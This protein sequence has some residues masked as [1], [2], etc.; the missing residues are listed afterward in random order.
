MNDIPDQ[1]DDSASQPK[2]GSDSSE[3]W[4]W[5]GLVIKPLAFLICG[6]LL[7]AGLGVMQK[8][9]FLSSGGGHGL[10]HAGAANSAAEYICPMMCT[11]PQSQPG[12]CPVCAM[13]LVVASSGGSNGDTQSVQIGSAARRI[14]N[15]QTAQATLQP[16]VRTVR[17]IGKLQYDEASLKTITAYV[18]GRLDRLY[19]DYTGVV[20]QKGDPLAMLYSPE[21]YSAQVEYLLARKSVTQASINVLPSVAEANRNLLQNARQQLVELGMTESQ[22]LSLESQAKA[23]SRLHLYSPMSG[24]VIQKLAVEGQYVQTNDPIYQLADLSSVWLMLELFPEDAASIGYGQKVEAEVQSHPGKKF[25]GRVAFV[26]PHVDDRTRTIAVRVALPNYEG[27]LKVGDF[28]TACLRLPTAQGPQLQ[29]YDSELAG[30]WISPRFPNEIFEQ[31]GKCP[32][33]HLDLVPTSQYGFAEQPQQETQAVSVPKSAVLMAGNSSVVYVETEPGRFE[34]RRVVVGHQSGNHIAIHDGIK[35]GEHVAIKGNFLIDSQMQLAGNP[36]LINPEKYI[37]P[38]ENKITPEMLAALE[39]LTPEDHT[40]ATVQK[41]CPVTEMAL[42]SMGTPPKAEV[43]DRTVFLCCEG[44]RSSLMKEPKRYLD[45]L[46]DQEHEEESLGSPELPPIGPV[47]EIS[48]VPE[49][50]PHAV[51]VPVESDTPAAP[52][53]AAPAI[54]HP[55]EVVR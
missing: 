47:Q 53:M 36:S 3:R 39:K 45:V 8:L 19:A 11:P 7:F 35:P 15:I 34:I 5:I 50:P 12:R 26:D 44:C 20:V 23:D 28:A 31:P 14:A 24:T 9:G 42:G 6:T 4:W 10:S 27:L 46:D 18:G 16:M 38:Q 17:A 54:Q 30:R 52:S 48:L 43:N 55:V 37:A 29:R 41:I 13:E 2:K 51:A 33:S 21:L 40:L 1:I 25:G 32:L 22:I 49:L